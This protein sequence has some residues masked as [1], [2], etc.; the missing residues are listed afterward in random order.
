FN[1]SRCYELASLWDG[2]IHYRLG[3]VGNFEYNHQINLRL[4][5]AAYTFAIWANAG[6]ANR[7]EFPFSVKT[8]KKIAFIRFKNPEQHFLLAW[9]VNIPLAG[10]ITRP[11]FS[12]I[13]HFANGEFTSNLFREM[14]DHLQF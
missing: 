6:V 9:Q 4:E 13:R 8:E 3:Y 1:T 5:N 14:G 10:V 7:F 11:N 2:R 12:G